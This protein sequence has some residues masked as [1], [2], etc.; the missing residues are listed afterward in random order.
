MANATIPT[1][2]ATIL[3]PTAR[4][5]A[6]LAG[7]VTGDDVAGLLPVEDAVPEAAGTVALPVTG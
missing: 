3:P 2:A 5:P 4:A 7:A 6:P 1:A